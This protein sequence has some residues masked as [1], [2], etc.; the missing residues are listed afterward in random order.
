M[1]DHLR[2]QDPGSLP[3]EWSIPLWLKQT[4]LWKNILKIQ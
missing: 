1:R 3:L 4:E 2:L